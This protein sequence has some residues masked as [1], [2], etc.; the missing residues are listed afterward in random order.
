MQRKIILF[1]WMYILGLVI[2]CNLLQAQIFLEPATLITITIVL[3]AVWVGAEFLKRRGIVLS[4]ALLSLLL[5]CAAVS[6]GIGRYIQRSIVSDDVLGIIE[7]PSQGAVLTKKSDIKMTRRLKIEKLSETK[8][9]IAIQVKGIFEK[10]LQLSPPVVINE[11]DPIGTIYNVMDQD[12]FFV[13]FDEVSDVLNLGKGEGRLKLYKISNHISRFAQGDFSG[14][15]ATIVGYVSAGPMVYDYQVRL[16]FTP[17][18][19]QLRPGGAIYKV[20][21]GTIQLVIR[22]TLVDYDKLAVS[23]AYGYRLKVKAPLLFPEPKK[24]PGG[25]DYR[26]YL[27]NRDIYAT[28]HLFESRRI[29]EERYAEILLDRNGKPYRGNWFVEFS[30]FVKD[31]ITKVIKQTMPYPESSFLGGVTLGLRYALAKTKCPVPG[32]DQLIT[33]EF[34]WTGVGHV[35]AV[36]GLHV[37]IISMMFWGILILLHLPKK[38][39]APFIILAIIMFTIITGARP[40]TQRAAIMNSLVILSYTY[41]AI[42]LQ[43]SILFGVSV[44]ALF[45]LALNPLMVFDPGFTLSFVA[46][47]GLGLMTAP[48]AHL[49][50]RLKGLPFLAFILLVTMVTVIGCLHW[51]LLI[52]PSFYLPLA[53]VISLLFAASFPLNK[54]YPIIG[55]FGFHRLPAGLNMFIGAQIAIQFSMMIPLSAYYFGRWPPAGPY[56]NFIA[57]PLIGIIVQ[58]GI[59]AGVLGFIPKIGIHLALL[60]NAANWVFCKIFL[61]IAHLATKIFPYPVTVRPTVAILLGYYLILAAIVWSGYLMAKARRFYYIV[62][63]DRE[64]RK[65]IYAFCGTFI[66]LIAMILFAATKDIRKPRKELEITVA[67][68]GY[69][70][71][72]LIKT[73][74]GKRILIDGGEFPIKRFGYGKDV[75]RERGF[76]QGERT[77]APELLYQRIRHL[78]TVILSSMNQEH[79]TG[80]TYIVDNFRIDKLILPLDPEKL[81]TRTSYDE[82]IDILGDSYM[83]RQKDKS[84]N[85]DYW[86]RFIK[87]TDNPTTLSFMQVVE[88]HRKGFFNRWAGMETKIERAR[89]GKLIAGEEV[90]VDGEKIP[91]EIYLIN[92]QREH[93]NYFAKENN[94]IAIRVVYGETSLLYSGDMK[95]TAMLRVVRISPQDIGSDILIVPGHGAESDSYCEEFLKV[96]KPGKVIVSYGWPADSFTRKRVEKNITENWTKFIATYGK[97]NCFRTDLDGAIM[98]K[99]NGKEWKV[100]TLLPRER[101]PIEEEEVPVADEL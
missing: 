6:F 47:L 56:A 76:D 51:E 49:V 68:V 12:G 41:L 11:T 89:F 74:Q 43:A 16:P 55:D 71:A 21:G 58:L 85:K 59:F 80:L 63:T 73:P 35:L 46:I 14:P 38:I 64:T 22:Q 86:Y 57:I 72:I 17:R 77:V 19:I 96:V 15:A 18:R 25:F 99:S 4:R 52:T 48:S 2:A 31:E 7:C 83:A 94:S 27:K 92:P 82:F 34:K 65:R 70:N 75:R 88:K 30:L 10:N 9:K 42:G 32:C 66:L 93:I 50:S 39:F 69:G 61:W 20:T 13:P 67:S 36:S 53:L 26:Q 101:M 87:G 24:N 90:I 98:L 97:E 3:L 95:K 100:E 29:K 8:G 81:T 91:F 40:P 5:I 28:M 54:R 78:D 37:T 1:A 33:D 23:E 62:G 60:L 79:F 45:I 84:Y 44:A